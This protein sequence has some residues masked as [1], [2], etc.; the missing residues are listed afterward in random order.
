VEFLKPEV[1]AGGRLVLGIDPER[2]KTQIG[3]TRKCLT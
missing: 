3:K 1:L 2:K